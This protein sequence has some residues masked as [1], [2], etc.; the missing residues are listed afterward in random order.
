MNEY[1]RRLQQF[2]LESCAKTSSDAESTLLESSI[3]NSSP[4]N[5]SINKPLRGVKPSEMS[6]SIATVDVFTATP[7]KGNQLAIVSVP[8]GDE[9]TQQAKQN[10]AREFN[11]SETVFLHEASPYYERQIEIFTPTEELPFAGHP[12]IGAACYIFQKLE[13]GLGSITLLCKAGRLEAR[14]DRSDE[15]AE[16][17]VPSNVRIHKHT[18]SA[19]AVLKAQDYLARTSVITSVLPVVSIVKGMSFILIQLPAVQPHLEKLDPRATGVDSASVKLDEGFSPSFVGCY[20]YAI[21]TTPDEK[22][23]RI[24]TRMIEPGL[25]GE[26]SATGS[27]ACTLASY[28]AL[29]QG[30]LGKVH[31]F[32][33]EQGVEMGRASDIRVRVKIASE[34]NV[35]ESVSLAGRAVLVSQGSMYAPKKSMAG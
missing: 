11:F 33:I 18:L 8:Q 23:T 13:P 35:I 14:Y 28:L 26:D 6:L 1:E 21:T 4:I 25:N 19:R 16:V 12:V 32:S 20:F 2:T 29:K 31:Q 5:S 9:L 27:A 22:V 3:D 34:A 24:R 30:R 10:I 17:E 15:V 7:F